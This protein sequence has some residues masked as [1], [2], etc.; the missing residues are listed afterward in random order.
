VTVTRTASCP[1]RRNS[2]SFPIQ[3]HMPYPLDPFPVGCYA[4]PEASFFSSASSR[5]RFS[6]SA[7][8]TFS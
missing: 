2:S 8:Q 6:F 7:R 1:W 5:S 3:S 4:P